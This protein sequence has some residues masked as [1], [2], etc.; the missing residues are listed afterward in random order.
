MTGLEAAD[1]LLLFGLG[2]EFWSFVSITSKCRCITR[3]EGDM[4]ERNKPG[5]VAVGRGEDCGNGEGLLSQGCGCH[6]AL[7]VI[8]WE[9]GP[10]VA[11]ASTVHPPT[12]EKPDAWIFIENL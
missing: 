7:T 2:V 10:S 1:Q 3:Q 11:R 12:Q 5:V 8:K 9:C 6:P 4:K